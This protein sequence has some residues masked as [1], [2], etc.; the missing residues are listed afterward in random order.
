LNTGAEAQAHAA[1]PFAVTA[2]G[3]RV[4]VRVTPRASADRV[5]GTMQDAE[6]IVALKVSVTAPPEDGKAN[7]ALVRLLA[8]EW[9]VPK[10]AVS[11]IAG[12]ADR[13]KLL[14]VAGEPQA[15]AQRLERWLADRVGK[16][17]R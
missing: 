2:D 3:L 4:R 15:L 17:G 6:G 12:A 14:H 9:G 13:R 16:P 8:R 11:V 10:S 5:T 1:L 7:A